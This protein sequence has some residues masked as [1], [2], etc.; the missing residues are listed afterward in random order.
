MKKIV[1][2]IIAYVFFFCVAVVLVGCLGDP[3]IGS[4]YC[5]VQKLESN[6]SRI[7]IMVGWSLKVD[8][9]QGEIVIFKKYREYADLRDEEELKAGREKYS[10]SPESKESVSRSKFKMALKEQGFTQANCGALEKL[11]TDTLTEI[12]KNHNR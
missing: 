7:S 12:K 9:I 6:L 10:L 11:R 8:D 4:T 3:K 1:I 2:S 5:K